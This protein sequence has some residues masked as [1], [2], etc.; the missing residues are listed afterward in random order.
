M[1]KKIKTK[2]FDTGWKEINGGNIYSKNRILEIINETIN[3]YLKEQEVDA[4]D[5]INIQYEAFRRQSDYIRD[6]NWGA[7]AIVCYRK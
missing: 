3:D 2:Y 6:D 5:V 4:E 7:H 1:N